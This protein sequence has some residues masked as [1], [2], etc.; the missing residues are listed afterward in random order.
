MSRESDA[1][2]KSIYS[3]TTSNRTRSA[4]PNNSHFCPAAMLCMNG[5]HS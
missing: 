3:D 1:I 4:L 5:P 2:E